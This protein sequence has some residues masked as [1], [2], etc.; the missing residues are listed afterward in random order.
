MDKRE[1]L[2]EEL[3]DLYY[4]TE[5]ALAAVKALSP[6]AQ[7]A[8]ARVRDNLVEKQIILARAIRLFDERPPS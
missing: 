8:L 5:N 1:M 2:K 6:S 3:R 4:Q 7:K